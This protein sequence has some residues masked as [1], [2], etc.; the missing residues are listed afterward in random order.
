M[1]KNSISIDKNC[2]L[3]VSSCD[4]YSDLWEPFFNLFKRYWSDCEMPI[5]LITEEKKKEIQN[6]SFICAGK[7]SNWSDRLMYSIEKINKPYVILMLE[8]F[9]LRSK[10]SNENLN[11]IFNQFVI[12]DMNMIRLIDRTG[13]NLNLDNSCNIG[14]IKKGTPFRVSTQASIWKS[15]ILKKLLIKDESIWEFEIN[16]T[17]RAEKFENFYSVISPIFTYKHH[18]VERGKWFPWSALYFSR[19]NIGVDLK[20]RKIMSLNATI[21]WLLFKMATPIYLKLPKYMRKILSFI[22][23]KFKI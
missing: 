4:A 1:K 6:V 5:Y 8:D 18:V 22:R 10:I 16:G 21:Y 11:N 12:K 15:K 7:D 2:A 9:F 19:L 13:P 17:T 23:K 14:Q 3:I 20:K